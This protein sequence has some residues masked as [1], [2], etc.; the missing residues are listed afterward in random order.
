MV[1]KPI[2]QMSD[3]RDVKVRAPTRQTTKMLAALGAVPVGMP[4]PQVADALSKGV[5]DG[6]LLPYEIMPTIKVHELT[7]FRSEADP[8]EARIYNSVFILAMNKAKYDSLAPDLK[9]IIDANSGIGL[10]AR[11]GKLFDEAEAANRKLVPANSINIISKAET[12]NWKKATQ[13][14]ID[15][16]LKEIGAKGLDGKKLLQQAQA[17]IAKYGK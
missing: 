4:V 17:L 16:W 15:G 10:S 5:I 9:K 14:V 2:K 11:I 13:P 6:A 12:A 3:L 7:R 8:A 1:K